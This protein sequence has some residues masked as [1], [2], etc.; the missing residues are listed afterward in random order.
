VQCAQQLMWLWLND[1]VIDAVNRIVADH[2]QG[3]VPQS[4]LVVQV[5]GGFDCVESGFQLIYD[6]V[7][8]VAVCCQ[9][10]KVMFANSMNEVPRPP[11]Y[12]RNG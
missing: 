8:W 10:N 7:H 2:V 9:N 6:T 12:L 11:Y 1:K 4:S 3:D 5:P